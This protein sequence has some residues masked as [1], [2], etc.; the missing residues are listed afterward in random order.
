M[1]QDV[2]EVRSELEGCF[3]RYLGGLQD[4]GVPVDVTR[5]EDDAEAGTSKQSRAGFTRGLAG[6]CRSIRLDSGLSAKI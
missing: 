6:Y 2:E 5:S 4:R 3:L 1:I